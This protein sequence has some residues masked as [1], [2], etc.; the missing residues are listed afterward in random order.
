M[1]YL[2]KTQKELFELIKSNDNFTIQEL[3]K[4]FEGRETAIRIHA[5]IDALEDCGIVENVWDKR[6]SMWIRV[7]KI[8]ECAKGL[9]ISCD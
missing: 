9:N 2:N 5:N 4:I 7:F 8:R 6:D 1:I 3:I